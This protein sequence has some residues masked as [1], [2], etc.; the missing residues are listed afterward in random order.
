MRWLENL[1]ASTE[2][3]GQ[4]QRCVHVGDQESDIFDLFGMAQQ[5]E[6]HF[7]VRTRGNRLADGSPETVAETSG[8]VHAGDCI[9]SLYE[10]VKA[11]SQRPCWKSATGVYA[12][13]PPGQEETLSGT[14]DYRDRG[15]RTR[16]AVRSGPD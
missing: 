10:T 11:K 3:L 1:R 15:A 12:F 13:R 5:L 8:E 2:L 14:D 6:T 9:A 16:N 4:P 7:L